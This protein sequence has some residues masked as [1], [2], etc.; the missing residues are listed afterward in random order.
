MVKQGKIYMSYSEFIEKLFVQKTRDVEI[1]LNNW[2]GIFGIE[3]MII[4]PFEYYKVNKNLVQ[5]FLTT[6][7]VDRKIEY[8]IP[9]LKSNT[10][11]SN[12]VIRELCFLSYVHHKIGFKN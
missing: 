1:N 4:K 12:E 2:S 11:L 6:V 7:G 3:N 5:D 9:P 10:S 8:H